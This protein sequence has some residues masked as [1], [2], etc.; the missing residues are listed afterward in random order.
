MN[1]TDSMLAPSQISPVEGTLAMTVLPLL[2]TLLL[3]LPL[4]TT[5]SG[6][7]LL[8]QEIFSNGTVSQE[9][10]LVGDSR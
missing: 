1:I 4:L 5:T 6:R 10:V 7:T 3:L 9:E 2:T 8:K